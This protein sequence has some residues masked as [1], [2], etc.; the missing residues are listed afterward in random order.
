MYT[1]NQK[2]KVLEYIL[3]L[4]GIFV[5]TTSEISNKF[6]IQTQSMKIL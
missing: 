3:E 4:I 6:H 5:T 2:F 1:Y